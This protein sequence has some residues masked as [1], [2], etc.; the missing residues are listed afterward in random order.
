M[1]K[2][3]FKVDFKEKVA[4]GVIN[5]R[6]CTKIVLPED[7]TNEQREVYLEELRKTFPTKQEN[8]MSPD[9]ATRVMETLLNLK[10]EGI[11]TAEQVQKAIKKVDYYRDIIKE[12]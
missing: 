7:W 8:P 12:D 3:V 2:S 10:R 1:S 9:E 5:P 11:I 6:S 4:M